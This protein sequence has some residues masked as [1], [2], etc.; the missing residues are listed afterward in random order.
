MP[1]RRLRRKEECATPLF[2][3]RLHI[4]GLRYPNDLA[5]II[6]DREQ[7][8]TVGP[9][10]IAQIPLQ[11]VRPQCRTR[12]HVALQV[13]N[14]CNQ[15]DVVDAVSTARRPAERSKVDEAVVTFF[16]TVLA[17]RCQRQ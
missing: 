12:S 6:L 3:Q 2:S 14:T 15:P 13:R 7:N 5:K 4:R 9:S 16:L 8:R 11:S 17:G 1:I 10:Q